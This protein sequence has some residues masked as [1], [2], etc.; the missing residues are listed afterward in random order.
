[1]GSIQLGSDIT[2]EISSLLRSTEGSERCS[3]GVS[4]L[5]SSWEVVA[6]FARA[7]AHEFFALGMCLI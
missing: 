1:M 7:S 3:I 5:R 4:L 6:S 2:G